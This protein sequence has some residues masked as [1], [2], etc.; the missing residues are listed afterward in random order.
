MYDTIEDMREDKAVY[1]AVR[2]AIVAAHQED[3]VTVAKLPL[4]RPISVCRGREF[5]TVSNAR[6]NLRRRGRP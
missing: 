6:F 5:V 3:G 2:A 1:R 4:K